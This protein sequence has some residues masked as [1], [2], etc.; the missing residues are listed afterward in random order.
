MS[1]VPEVCWGQPLPVHES[2]LL[3]AQEFLELVDK[4]SH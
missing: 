3:R 2:Q 1:S 4:H